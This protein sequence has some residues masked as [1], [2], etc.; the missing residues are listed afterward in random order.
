[1][2]W[3]KPYKMTTEQM[4]NDTYFVVRSN[5]RYVSLECQKKQTILFECLTNE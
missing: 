2:S 1:M 5:G 3:Y 4:K